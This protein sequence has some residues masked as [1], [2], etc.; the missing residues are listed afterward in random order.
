M[1]LVGWLVVAGM[2]VTAAIALVMT[3]AGFAEASR[4]SAS[5]MLSGSATAATSSCSWKAAS[6]HVG[7]FGTAPGRA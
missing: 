4:T 6:L 3:M 1:G 5:A 7:Y 2:W